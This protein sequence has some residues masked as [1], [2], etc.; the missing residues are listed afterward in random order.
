MEIH[1]YDIDKKIRNLNIISSGVVLSTKYFPVFLEDGKERIFKPLSKTKP[2]QTPLFAYSEVYWS[3]FINKYID[4]QTPIYSLATCKN[5][6]K[7]QNKYYEKGCIVD[8]I[9]NENEE[10][11]NLLEL[12]RKYPDYQVDIDDYINYCEV[13]YDY[14][15]VLRST[16]F[17]INRDLGEELAKQ[18]LCSILRRDENYH[19]ENVSFIQE[20]GKIKKIAPMM[21]M[22]YSQMFMY[23][24]EIEK[25]RKRFSLYDE[26]MGVIFSYNCDLDFNDNYFEFLSKL[27]GDCIYD[28]YDEYKFYNLKNNIKTITELYPNM[29]KDFLKRLE[30]MRKEVETTEITLSDEFLG[31][32]SSL[33]WIPT[34]MILKEG[35]TKDSEEYKYAL[36]EAINKIAN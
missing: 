36:K 21:D 34:R 6:S 4:S 35:K 32:F 15:K 23:P 5:L 25:H 2:Y 30:S 18:I 24:D 20:N 8:N 22:E 29:C 16:F 7:E 10:L 13:Q 3:Y 11:I 28:K 9:L 33:D 14:E 31:T 27:Y 26:G 17:T 19:Y 12:F 1:E